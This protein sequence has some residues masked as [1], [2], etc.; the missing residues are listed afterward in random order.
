MQ[1]VEA[2]GFQTKLLGSGN[3]SS[4]RLQL[5]GMTCSSCS[6]AIEARLQGTP[7]VAEASVSLITSSAEVR[8]LSHPVPCLLWTLAA[9]VLHQKKLDTWFMSSTASVV[10]MTEAVM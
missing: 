2:L 1:A 7:G 4:L 8:M 5:G 9:F 10:F 3:A 6:N